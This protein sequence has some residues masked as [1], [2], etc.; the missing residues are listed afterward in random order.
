M[1]FLKILGNCEHI[2][3]S[4]KSCVKKICL[5]LFITG[6]PLPFFCYTYLTDDTS[7]SEKHWPEVKKGR[8]RERLQFGLL[9]DMSPLSS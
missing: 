6:F 5:T 4:V 8:F 3:A 2:K 9:C 1:P 7:H